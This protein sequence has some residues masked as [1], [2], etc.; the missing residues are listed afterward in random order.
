M[1]LG[2]LTRNIPLRPQDAVKLRIH[3][4]VPLAQVL[5]LAAFVTHAELQQNSSRGRIMLEMRSED[6]VQL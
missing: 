6:A 3:E 5:A 2:F 4:L 1:L